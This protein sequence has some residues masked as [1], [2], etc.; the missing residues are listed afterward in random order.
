MDAETEERWK[1]TRER[2]LTADPKQCFGCKRKGIEVK[3]FS[4]YVM[5]GPAGLPGPGHLPMD[6]LEITL[7]RPCYGYLMRQ[8]GSRAMPQG[9]A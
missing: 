3:R 7:C 2:I 4:T 1:A 8:P 6:A 5:D 9:D